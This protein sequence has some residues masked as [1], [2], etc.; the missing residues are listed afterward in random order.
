MNPE[1]FWHTLGIGSCF[2]AVTL[3]SLALCF[4]I[5]ALVEG[6]GWWVAER[7]RR[8]IAQIDAE[9]DAKSEQLRRTILS[10]AEQLA[11]EQGEASRQMI[12]AAFLVTGK[13]TPLD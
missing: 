2:L 11:A 5:N 7:R 13:T 3:L 8:R 4:L 10:L 12:R 1:A 9:L 6:V